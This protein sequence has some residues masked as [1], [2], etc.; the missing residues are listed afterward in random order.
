MDGELDGYHKV[1]SRGIF[2][3]LQVS[4]QECFT[5]LSLHISNIHAKKKGIVKKF[6]LTLRAISSSQEVD[7]VAGDFDGIAWR[8]R[9]RD[10][11]TTIDEAFTDCATRGTWIHSGQ[12]GRRLWICSNHLVLNAL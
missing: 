12:L 9:I 1:F 6:I 2:R 3:C 7:L 10:N 4:G 8:Y 5:V 11:V